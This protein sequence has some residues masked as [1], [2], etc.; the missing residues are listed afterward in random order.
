LA[1]CAHSCHRPTHWRSSGSVH[2]QMGRNNLRK[3]FST[4]PS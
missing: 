4:L 1:I 3:L 2:H